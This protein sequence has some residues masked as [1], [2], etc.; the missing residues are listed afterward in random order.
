MVGVVTTDGAVVAAAGDDMLREELELLCLLIAAAGALTGQASGVD[1]EVICKV[2]DIRPPP[3]L[4]DDVIDSK[5]F[6]AM[7]NRTWT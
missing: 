4:L 1:N 7:L 5:E 2:D 3:P 6:A